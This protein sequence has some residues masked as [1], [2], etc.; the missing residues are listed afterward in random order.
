M[1]L[2]V[3]TLTACSENGPMNLTSPAFDEGGAIPR[4]HT[5]DGDD[6]SPPLTWDGAPEGTAAFALIVEDP[7]AGGF[8]HWVL[9]DIPGD[10][11]DLPDGEADSIGTP[12][13]NDFGRAGWG[14]P[15]PPSGEHR[16]RFT[17]YA[18]S[19]ELSLPGTTDAASVRA[20]L[21]GRVL[22][23]AQLTGVYERGG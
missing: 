15:C 1:F 8:I 22:A 17:L 3:M 23:E 10:T 19:E 21:E 13:R 2:L 7:D 16:Y 5:C 9:I 6:R 18:L 14:G 11:A 12:G 20:A 4:E